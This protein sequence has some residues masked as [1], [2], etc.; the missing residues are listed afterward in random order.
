MSVRVTLVGLLQS[1]TTAN[2]AAPETPEA[3]ADAYR[4]EVLNEEAD[5]LEA[6]CPDKGGATSF[7]LCQCDAA[8]QLRRSAA[9]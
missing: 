5:R 8:T 9:N 3:V 2:N 1:W 7:M 4:A 6:A